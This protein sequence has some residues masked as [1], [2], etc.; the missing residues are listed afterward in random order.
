MEFIPSC[1]L[2]ILLYECTTWTLTK[3]I[4]KLDGNYTRMLYA[5]LIMP[6]SK[7]LFIFERSARS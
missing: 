4:E 2:S 1:G 3:C 6:A 5:N 7:N